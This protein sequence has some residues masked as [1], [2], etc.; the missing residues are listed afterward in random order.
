M[1]KLKA[2]E[3]SPW[4]LMVGD[5][6]RGFKRVLVVELI[7]ICEALRLDAADFVRQLQQDFGR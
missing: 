7:G 4:R 2:E 5:V 6:P 3:V 1:E